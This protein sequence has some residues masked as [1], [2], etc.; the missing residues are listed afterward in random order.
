MINDSLDEKYYYEKLGDDFDKFI[1]DYDVSRRIYLIFEYLLPKHQGSSKISVLEIG[2]GTGR[3]SFEIHKR[4]WQLTV[5]D[6]SSKLCQQVAHSLNCNYLVGDCLNLPCQDESYDM[7]ISSE[8]IEHTVN[9]WG[10]LKEMKRVLKRG[11]WLTVT[12]PNKLW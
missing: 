6:I 12:T 3:I 7:I 11:G 1:S 8:C 10:A 5:N 4:P 9:P 2:C